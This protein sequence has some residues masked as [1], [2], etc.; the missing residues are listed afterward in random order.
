MVTDDRLVELA[1]R[2]RTVGG[3]LRDATPPVHGN[4]SD[5]LPGALR[6]IA[7]DLGEKSKRFVVKIMND[8]L[9]G[10]GP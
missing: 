6:L 3:Q 9:D 7:I 8:A 5:R 1:H 2:Q 4:D 10:F